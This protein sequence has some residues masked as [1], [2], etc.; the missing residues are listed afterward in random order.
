M[1]LPAINRAIIAARNTAI[2]IEV[3]Q[4]ASAIESYK[5]DKGDY[6]P[7]FRDQTVVV[8]HIRE[9]YPKADPTYITNFVN[10]ACGITNNTSFIDEGES[11]VFWLT[12]TDTDP[13][14]P[15][16]S[17]LRRWERLRTP[18]PRNITTSTNQRSCRST[19]LKANS[20]QRRSIRR[21]A[22]SLRQ[23]LQ[24]NLP[25]LHR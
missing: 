14:Y 19:R 13:R 11:L 21:R 6:P 22:G 10:Y 16:R 15:F 20:Q 5:Q 8:R 12:M 2:A 24:R 17:I 18:A 7:N 1:L 4:L 23:E 25:H 9:C 3:N